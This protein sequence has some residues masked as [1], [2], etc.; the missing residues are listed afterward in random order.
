[1][2]LATEMNQNHLFLKLIQNLPLTRKI[3][4]VMAWERS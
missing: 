3:L 2:T 4:A 1:M